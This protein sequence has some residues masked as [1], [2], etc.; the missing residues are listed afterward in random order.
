MSIKLS[1]FIHMKSEFAKI[2]IGDFKV[3]IG[4]GGT[5]SERLEERAKLRR[6]INELSARA[7]ELV[8]AADDS[9]TMEQADGL[10]RAMETAGMVINHLSDMMD[11]DERAREMWEGQTRDNGGEATLRDQGGNKIGVLLSNAELRDTAK[12]ATKLGKEPRAFDHETDEDGNLTGFFRGIAG[13]RTTD[14]IRASLSEGTD[15]EGGHAVPSWLLPGILSALVPA[16]S[17]LNAGANIAVLQQQGDSFKIAA[18]DSVPTAAWRSESGN[19]S[20][21]EPTFRAVTVVPRSLAFIFKV[22]RELLM[23]A[24]G[25]EGALRTAISQAFAAEIDRAGL[26]GTGVTPE[27]AGI[28]NTT[29]INTYSMGD[30][31]AELKNYSPIIKARRTIADDNAPPPTAIITSNREAETI[32]LF[33]DTTGQPL[34]RPPALDQMQFLATSQ[35][36]VDDDQG[37]ASNASSMFLGDF[38][39][40]TLYMREAL[41]VQKLNER[42]ADTGEIGFACHS[43]VDLGLAYPSAFCVIKGV[44]PAAAT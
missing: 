36:P 2:G 34:R 4:N 10:T 31:G 39:L 29:G 14:A 41:S 33:A 22:S 6:G 38:S 12:I 20:E 23:D 26:I 27:I 15:S 32:D 35:I 30:D 5:R 1:D 18:V 37:T 44:I 25:I 17:M 11:M 8:D 13:G 40:A 21:S 16:S 3:G 7:R 19:L 43:R 9:A 42:Y 24:P 28:A